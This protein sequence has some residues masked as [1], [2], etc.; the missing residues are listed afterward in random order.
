[1]IPSFFIAE[2]EG[3][4]NQ[5]NLILLKEYLQKVDALLQASVGAT[6]TFTQPSN[7]KKGSVCFNTT[8]NEPNWWDGNAWVRAISDTPLVTG[9]GTVGQIPYFSAAS[10]LS[11]TTKL[12]WDNTNFRFEVDG[13]SRT[14][15]F[16]QF[17]GSTAPLLKCKKLIGTTGVN[18]GDVANIAHGVTVTKILS[19]TAHVFY[20]ADS[21]IEPEF[22]YTDGFR[23]SISTDATDIRIVTVTGHSAN[24]L[25]KNIVI[26]MWYEE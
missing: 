23:F 19:I 25:S 17:G 14:N 6:T 26:L 22:S 1:M 15:S 24:I 2:T 8:T 18:Q 7:L 11:G 13:Y 12:T 16:S 3:Q 10:I 5:K 20:S 9:S 4:F 21:F